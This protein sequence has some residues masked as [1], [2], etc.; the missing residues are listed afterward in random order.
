VVARDQRVAI[1]GLADLRRPFS[2]SAQPHIGQGR[3]VGRS[4]GE[5]AGASARIGKDRAACPIDVFPVDAA[6]QP[7]HGSTTVRQI[8]SPGKPLEYH[9]AFVV[10]EA[11]LRDKAIRTLP[12]MSTQ[13]SPSRVRTQARPSEKPSAAGK[14]RSEASR[15]Y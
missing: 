3:P 5:C 13:P 9:H 2:A 12:D 6:L 8:L 10:D 4:F 14:E 11:Q 15:P 1:G 7:L